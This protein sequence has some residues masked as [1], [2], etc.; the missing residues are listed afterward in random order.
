MTWT[1]FSFYSSHIAALMHDHVTLCY[2]IYYIWLFSQKQLD[3]YSMQ[4][5]ALHETY[6]TYRVSCYD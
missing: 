4:H 3:L 5:C 6:D 2:A 1:F